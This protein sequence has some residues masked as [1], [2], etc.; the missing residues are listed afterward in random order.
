MNGDNAVP[1]FTVL[2]GFGRELRSQYYDVGSSLEI[3]CKVRIK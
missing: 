2:D 1:Q 3:C